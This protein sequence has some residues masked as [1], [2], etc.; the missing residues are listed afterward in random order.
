MEQ[1]AMDI[2]IVVPVYNEV[3]SIGPLYTSLRSTLDAV[4][5]EYEIV[6]VDDGSRDGSTEKLEQLAANDDRVK[7]V[8]L[9]RNFGQ[10]AAMA[11]GLEHAQ[12]DAV[13]TMDADLQNDPA[14]IP[15]MLRKLDAGYDLVHGWRRERQDTFLNRRLPS[16]VANWL[17]ARVTGF[18]VRDLGCTLKVMRREI[19]RELTLYGE[20]HRFIPILAHWQGA[21]CVEVET[22]H[23][24]RRY[25]TTK[26]G[27]S[28]T[29]RVVLDLITVKYL[30][31]YSTSPMR[32]FGGIGLGCAAVGLVCG[33]AALAMK[34][35]GFDVTGNPLLYVA[36]F[37]EMLGLQFFSLGMLGEVCARIYYESQGRKPYTVRR[38]LNVPPRQLPIV[39]PTSRAA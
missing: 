30:I 34:L 29:F 16:L 12:G 5:G 4:K 39:R 20:M 35:G 17:I 6:F 11:A 19:A 32:L 24:P 13:V 14:D 26:Y 33:L 7:V 2:S 36:L 21:R 18:P 8:Q 27:I 37:S 38:L 23:H 3:D 1:D 9:R 22:R 31:R 25:G 15:Q 28:R 10:T